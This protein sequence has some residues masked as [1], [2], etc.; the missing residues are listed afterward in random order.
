MC[1]IIKG[2]LTSSP[3]ILSDNLANTLTIFLKMKKML[4][5]WKN[6]LLAIACADTI[7]YDQ[8]QPIKYFYIK[9]TIT[10]GILNGQ[11]GDS[12]KGT[13]IYRC[14]EKRIFPETGY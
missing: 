6:N 8:Y 2:T 9:A 13:G 4:P 5:E 3:I 11:R 1:L 7:S 14:R 12:G 10:E